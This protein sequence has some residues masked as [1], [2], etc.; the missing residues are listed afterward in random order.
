MFFLEAPLFLE[1]F[2]DLLGEFDLYHAGVG[3]ISRST[4]KKFTISYEAVNGVP[5]A[6]IP[7]VVPSQENS[8]VKDVVWCDLGASA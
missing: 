8:N 3:F 4:G 7:F 2:R 5:A 6:A 1:W